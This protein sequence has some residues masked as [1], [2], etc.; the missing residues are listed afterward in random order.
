MSIHA[1]LLTA[2]LPLSDLLHV[3]GQELC[4]LSPSL[5]AFSIVQQQ[6]KGTWEQKCAYRQQL[7]VLTGGEEQGTALSSP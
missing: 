7:S 1:G 4:Y 3:L 5:L 6:V 2:T